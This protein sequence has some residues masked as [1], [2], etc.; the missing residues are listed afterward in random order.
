MWW[1]QMHHAYNRGAWQWFINR[2]SSHSNIKSLEDCLIFYVLWVEK[3]FFPISPIV[4]FFHLFVQ[5]Y[6]MNFIVIT[7]H[8][9]RI[10]IQFLS[11]CYPFCGSTRPFLTMSPIFVDG[12]GPPNFQMLLRLN[13]EIPICSLPALGA[14]L[15]N[16]VMHE[17]DRESF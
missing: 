11:P 15:L 14:I 17:F 12:L 3:Q 7:S 2:I 10:G 16:L 5:L 8:V 4:F 9:H 1:I 13:S 6:V